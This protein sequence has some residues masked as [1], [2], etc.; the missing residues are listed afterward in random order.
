M[1]TSP[2]P[3]HVTFAL[4]VLVLVGLGVYLVGPA[5]GSSGPGRPAHSTQATAPSPA[6][7]SPVAVAPASSPSAAP[8]I[9]QWLPFTQAGLTAAAS[10]ARRFGA[11]YGTFS[12]T[13]SADAYGA[14][15]R[16]VASTDLIGQIVAAYSLPGVAGPRTS[17][18]Q[19][20]SGSSVIESIRAFGATSLTFVVQVTENMTSTSG[21]SQ[22]VTP[23]A[24]TLTGGASTW[25]VTDVELAAAGNS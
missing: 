19:V 2:L 21:R 14:S 8:D 1:R 9:Y 6:L 22:V 4:V 25:Q 15:L 18:R 3:R 11:A 13:E 20:S 16:S 12:Y 24:I 5:R 17:G 10:V 7:T 23:Y